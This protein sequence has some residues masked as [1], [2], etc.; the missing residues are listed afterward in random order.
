[1]LRQASKSSQKRQNAVKKS[2]RTTRTKLVQ[3]QARKFSTKPIQQQQ[4]TLFGCYGQTG[5]YVAQYLG[6]TGMRMIAAYRDDGMT[7]RPLKV[8]GEVGQVVPRQFAWQNPDSIRATLQGTDLVI[9]MIGSST[10]TIHFN[11]YDANLRTALTLA[12]TAKEMGVSRFIH[13]SAAGASPTAGSNFLRAKYE[14][15]EAVKTY[16]PNATIVRPCFIYDSNNPYLHTLAI[17]ANVD[18]PQ[19]AFADT[20]IQPTY[21][22]DVGAAIAQLALHPEIDGQTWT[23]GGQEQLTRWEIFERFSNMIAHKDSNLGA[24]CQKPQRLNGPDSFELFRKEQ[25]L[26]KQLMNRWTPIGACDYF[27]EDVTLDTCEKTKGFAELGIKPS[28]TNLTFVRLGKAYL[29]NL[30][31]ANETK[32]FTWTTGCLDEKAPGSKAIDFSSGAIGTH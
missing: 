13:V 22:R 16:F 12:K 6:P 4:A 23:L 11:E 7:V 10:P 14:S 29:S 21:A 1:M 19:I 2:Q 28:D 26:F 30:S 5:P 32:L 24:Y 18:E 9:N 17:G 3:K 31:K 15:E 27:A 20:V 25:L 8:S